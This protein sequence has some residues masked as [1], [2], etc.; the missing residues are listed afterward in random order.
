ML[1]LSNMLK[2]ICHTHKGA[3][4]CLISPKKKKK[5]FCMPIYKAFTVKNKSH[6]ETK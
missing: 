6:F 1:K 5:I 2:N 3:T 4:L